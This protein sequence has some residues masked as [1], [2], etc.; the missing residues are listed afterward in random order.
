MAL[1]K[2]KAD[3]LEHSTAGSL[4][5]SYVVSAVPKAFVN[6]NA[7]SSNAIRISMNLSSLTDIAAGQHALN[8]SSAMS[9]GNLFALASVGDT[10]ST[11]GQRVAGIG[12]A[13]VPTTTQSRFDAIS[14]GNLDDQDHHSYGII[15]DLA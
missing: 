6:F 7:E 10:G 8:Y 13:F 1:G 15:G 5:T 12:D 3:T 9:S 11:T 4:D 2:I 14:N